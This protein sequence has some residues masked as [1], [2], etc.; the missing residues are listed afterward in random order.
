MSDRRLTPANTRVAA[1][2]LKGLVTAD[3][4]VEGT[5]AQVTAFATALHSTAN[6]PLDRQILFGD[7]VQ[8]YDTHDGWA[9]IQ[10]AKD[11][12]C[13]YVRADALG[14]ASVPTHAVAM[15]QTHVF[16]AEG[17][18]APP[19]MRLPFAAQVT[20]TGD[21]GTWAQI[22]WADGTGQIPSG[23]L[24]P[25]TS[26]LPDPAATAALFL[27]TPYLWAGNTGDGIDCSGLV[28]AAC[29]AAGLACPGDSD[30]QETAI[31]AALDAT[32]PL[33]RNDVLFWKGHVALVESSATMIHA[34]AWAMAVIREDIASAIA[35][36]EAATG[37]LTT[38]RR[39]L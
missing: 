30:L 6:G 22:A 33:Q 34:T 18:K 29:L 21:D 16:P 35:R 4:Y 25:L 3:R 1:A 9:F 17:F 8:V 19:I 31:G 7:R 23:H 24:R 37:D 27:G 26:P 12:Y 14:A 15:R 39:R 10:A 5:P 28:Q 32:T 20:V 38:A 2:H 11:G 36:I 13:G